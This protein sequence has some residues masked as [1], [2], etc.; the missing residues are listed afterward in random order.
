MSVRHPHRSECWEASWERYWTR[1]LG[2]SDWTVLSTTGPGGIVWRIQAERSPTGRV[3]ELADKFA[4]GRL[5]GRLVQTNEIAQGT[6]PRGVMTK[7]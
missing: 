6:D 7:D 3:G 5:E 4:S 2:D 1:P